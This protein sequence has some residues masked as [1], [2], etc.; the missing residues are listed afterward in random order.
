MLQQI[1]YKLFNKEIKMKHNSRKLFLN[2]YVFLR[3][4][5]SSVKLS[6]NIFTLK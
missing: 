5:F 2:I 4:H 6:G 1:F 3:Q